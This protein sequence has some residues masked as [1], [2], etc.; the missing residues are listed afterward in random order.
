MSKKK[1]RTA[2]GGQTLSGL[3]YSTDP[4]F[5]L[6]DENFEEQETVAPSEQKLKIRLDTKHRAGKAV[7]LVEGF[8]GTIADM[9]ELGKKLKSFC[10]TG[11]SVKDGEIIV[12]GDNREKILQWL[13]K[14]GYKSSKK[15]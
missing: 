14:N 6:P 9:E 2:S 11:G 5:K 15:I 8:K 13:Q 12:Q 1:I 3:V 7:T 10:G 4:N